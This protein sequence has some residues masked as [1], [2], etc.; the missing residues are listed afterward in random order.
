MMRRVS[1][2]TTHNLGRR[3][4]HKTSQNVNYAKALE[5]I[6]NLGIIAH[7]DAGK[8]TTT[9]RMLFYSGVVKNLG[10]VDEGS[11]VTDFLRDERERGITIQSAAVAFN[12][13][14]HQVNLIDTPGH[15]DFTLEVERSLRVMDGAVTIIEGVAGVQ[16][17]TETVWR[18]ATT[19]LL[20]NVIYVNKM[21]REGANFEHA[22][23][24]IR[25]R[26]QVKPIVVQI[27]IFDSNHRFRGVI[28]IIKKLAIQYSDDDELGLT[29]RICDVQELNSPELLQKYESAREDF[30]ENLADCDDGIM[31]K[32]LEGQDPSQSTV[33]ASLRRATIQRKLFPVLCGASLRNR[34]VHGLLDATVDYLPSPMDHPSFTVRKFDKSTKTIHV[35]DADHAAA[36]AFK[37]THDKHMGPLV[38]IR[39]YSGNLQSRHALYNVTQKQK[40]L[41]AK[42]LRVFADS[43]EEVA[44]ATL[45]GVYAVT[46]MKVTRTGDTLT[47]ASQRFH[48]ELDSIQVPEA[49]FF[50]ALE[51]ETKMDEEKLNEALALMLREDP[52]LT[53]IVNKET[54]QTLLG[55]MGELH[56]EIVVNRLRRDHQVELRMGKPRVAYRELVEREFE[57]KHRY[58]H[59]FGSERLE[60][61]LTVRV[62]RN[63]GMGKNTINLA[64]SVLAL[65]EEHAEAIRDGVRSALEAGPTIGL[66]LVGANVDV[67]EI[68]EEELDELRAAKPV[69]LQACAGAAVRAALRAS[70]TGIVEPV[71]KVELNVPE[72]FVSDV[73]RDLSR[74][75]GTVE[76]VSTKGSATYRHASLVSLA[77]LQELIGYSTSVRSA[78]QGAAAFSIHFETYGRPDAGHEEKILKEVRGY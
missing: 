70:G 78:T 52:S 25:D 58:D 62:S 61:T 69:S 41:P 65:G 1:V 43:V 12:W 42:F 75:R 27:P 44:A 73:I 13:K 3:Y 45:G 55:G 8:T 10:D 21:D 6:R 30:L 47:L 74:R 77:P 22:V 51:A 32:V 35:R 19:Y 56:L 15:V 40:E 4:A 7:I 59:V 60:A 29:P 63:E 34:G 28:D 17:Q 76:S 5:R 64:K 71:M 46:G 53:V 9:E 16:A 23:Q 36:L 68:P 26:L 14:D 2:V 50:V 49:V 54:G 48:A 67:L 57:I 20:P 24:T 11:T 39:V 31:D 72:R 66:P 18:Q 37:V 38:F 33:K